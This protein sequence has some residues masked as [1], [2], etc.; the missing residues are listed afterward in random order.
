[1]HF[2]KIKTIRDTFIFISESCF[3]SSEE[4]QCIELCT[5]YLQGG[6][7]SLDYGMCP[8]RHFCNCFD[9]PFFDTPGCINNCSDVGKEMNTSTRDNT[10]CKCVNAPPKHKIWIL[11]VSNLIALKV[12]SGYAGK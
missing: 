9:C 7:L 3:L 10:G 1:M 11:S 5:K 4:E 12:S 6:K 2:Q 8:F